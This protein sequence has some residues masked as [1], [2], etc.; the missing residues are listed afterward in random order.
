MEGVRNLSH[1][2][3]DSA[4]L[5]TEFYNIIIVRTGMITSL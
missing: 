4:M 2:G 5:I 3:L 1:L